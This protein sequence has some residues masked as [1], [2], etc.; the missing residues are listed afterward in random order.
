MSEDRLDTQILLMTRQEVAQRLRRG[1]RF[2]SGFYRVALVALAIASAAAVGQISSPDPLNAAPGNGVLTVVRENVADPVSTS[3]IQPGN[4]E[5]QH[6]EE[7][8]PSMQVAALA[9]ALPQG[10]LAPP[11]EAPLSPSPTSLTY[12]S[13]ARDL[14]KSGDIAAAR[15]FLERAA[16]QDSTG[17]ALFALAETYD[18]VA[19]GRW[20]VIGLRPDPVRSMEIYAMAAEQGHARARERF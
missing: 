18:P 20:R 15:V 9:E 19:L 2:R 11:R 13:R 6:A 4:P 7:S 10:L 1:R 5:R 12:I 14:I 8:Q 3:S 17:E 16:T